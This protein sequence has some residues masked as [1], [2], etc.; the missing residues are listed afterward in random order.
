MKV[1]IISHLPV[2]SLTNMGKTFLS[3]FSSFKKNEICN[4]Y[5]YP[6][7]PNL[8][9]C[10]SYYRITNKEALKSCF[11]W[12][13]IG[14]EVYFSESSKLYEQSKDQKLYKNPINKKA[15]MCMMR[16]IVWK[17]SHWYNKKL[18]YWLNKEK[19][20][21]I[22]LA[23]GNQKFIYK[24]ALKISKKH[25]IPIITYVCDYYYFMKSKKG[26]LSK[27]FTSKLKKVI[28]T[29]ILNSKAVIGICDSIKNDYENYFK[30]K[31]YKIMTGSNCEISNTIK[32]LS[33]ITKINYFGNMGCNRYISIFEVGNCIQEINEKLGKRHELHLYTNEKN[34]VILNK[35]RECKS[36]I[37]H[38]FVSGPEYNLI[39]NNFE[40]L[41]H[42]EAFDDESIDRVKHSISTK[43][44]DSLA[45]EIPMFAFGPLEV[46]SI[47]HLL[48]NECAYVCTNPNELETSLTDFFV[49]KNM[50]EKTIVNAY[51]T[52]KMYHNSIE[53]SEKLHE[54]FS[55]ILKWQRIK[56]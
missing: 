34:N 24:I 12:K 27:L 50:R 28:N 16:D 30:V 36:I 38:D 20:T 54:V 7:L 55:N 6:S 37:I 8:D 52:A 11:F 17:Y 26:L 9:V 29:T 44:A 41:L 45:S 15:I 18:I 46:A 1:L 25:N 19:P 42:V 32:N 22:F 51:K 23:P 56:I 33:V 13:A 39:F 43:I 4:L 35:L 21:H 10:L 14:E 48:K 53:N 5:I 2:S 49:N 40:A 47:E 3:L 31:S